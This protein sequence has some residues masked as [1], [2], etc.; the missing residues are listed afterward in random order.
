LRYALGARVV[1]RGFA[2]CCVRPPCRA[3]RAQVEDDCCGDDRDTRNAGIEPDAGPLEPA[4]HAIG[5]GEPEG[6][7]ARH[8]YR[9][10]AGHEM[11]RRERVELARPGGE[12][13]NRYG[14]AERPEQHRAAGAPVRASA[15]V[16]DP[17]PRPSTSWLALARTRPPR[18]RPPAD[19]W[20][21]RT[22]QR[23]THGTAAG[24]DHCRWWTPRSAPGATARQSASDDPAP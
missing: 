10:D 19:G 18:R 12:A 23:K 13:A 14:S 9:I 5:S 16:A 2:H 24:P 20:P 1:A 22:A 7:A 15:P 8:Q 4:H 3:P 17:R 11:G 6:G 21:H